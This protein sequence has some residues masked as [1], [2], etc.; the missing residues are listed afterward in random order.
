M[1]ARI[2]PAIKRRQCSPCRKHRIAT[3]LD[4]I[5]IWR[6]DLYTSIGIPLQEG[7]DALMHAVER[8]ATT[9][10]TNGVAVAVNCVPME[11]VRAL[12]D[13]GIRCLSF[14]SDQRVL[15][16]AHYEAAEDL[17]RLASGEC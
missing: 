1:T 15:L 10:E 13:T 16:A 2:N 8:A 17:G 14:L 4:L 6:E 7:N 9:C 5:E 3:R 11:D 12:V